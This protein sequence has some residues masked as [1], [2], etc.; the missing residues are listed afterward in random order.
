MNGRFVTAKDE[1]ADF[2][3]CWETEGVDLDALDPVLLDQSAGRQRQKDR[4]GGEL[5]PNVVRSGAD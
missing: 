4:F 1:P 5:F 3:A 2:D